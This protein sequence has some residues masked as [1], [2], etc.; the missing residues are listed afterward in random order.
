[1]MLLNAL[2]HIYSLD[3]RRKQHGFVANGRR[4]RNV[5]TVIKAG[6]IAT[7]LRR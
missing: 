3:Q 2:K 6:S 5:N 4:T 7:P 1:M